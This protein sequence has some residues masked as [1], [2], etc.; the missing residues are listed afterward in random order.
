MNLASPITITPPAITKADGTVK[1]FNPITLNELDVTIIDNAKR[2]SV[3]A[4]IRPCPRPLV[5]WTNEA[6]TTAGD[7]TQ[8]AVEARITELLG[9]DPKSV[10]EGLFAFPTPPAR[11]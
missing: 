11:K 4:Q 1:T 2:K 9:N 5:L 10:L 8:A 6:Y 3:V 7:Y